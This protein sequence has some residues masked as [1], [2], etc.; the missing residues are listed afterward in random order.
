[1][2]NQ[3]MMNKIEELFDTTEKPSTK[4]TGYFDVY[5]RHLAK[6]VG[7]APKILE[8]GVLGG[9]S[10]ELW[11]KYFGEGTQVIG[12]DIDTRCLA[13]KYE[14]NA[15]VIM[16]DQSNPA[17]WDEF[18]DKNTDFDI[19]IDDGSHIMEHQILTLQ[20]TFPHLK[21]GG[22]Y[23]CED[24][25]T[26]Y[27]PKWNGEYDKKGTFLDYSKYLT[28]IMNQQHF[29]QKMDPAVLK[30]FENLYSTAFYNS[31]VVL[32][33]EALKLFTIKDNSKITLN[34]G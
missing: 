32:E 1:M 34:I 4:W 25:H 24:T 3:Q 14:G 10:I 8:I 19:I 13:Y 28:D 21:T 5:E 17:F 2:W 6:F 9:G 18:L 20:K 23:I 27:W 7:K 30:T 33:K 16:G 22:V 12:V 31:M 29:Q 15:Q 11:L 26:S